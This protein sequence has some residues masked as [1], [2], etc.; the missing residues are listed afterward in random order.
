M[1]DIARKKRQI[2]AGCR[3][4]HIDSDTRHVLQLLVTGKASMSDMDETDLDLMLDELKEKGFEAGFNGKT[5]SKK[6]AAAPR[7]D[8]RY[9]HVLW[10]LLGDAGKLKRPSRDGLNTFVRTRFENKWQ[11]VPID[12]DTLRD[13]GQ[14]NDV[15][16]ALKEMC[17]RHGIPT[18]RQ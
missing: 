1:S 9:V 4:L 12:I 2:F 8:L 13:A 7:A 15:T 16:R 5:K 17:K 18:E 10:K 11:S 6:H 3:E 14:I